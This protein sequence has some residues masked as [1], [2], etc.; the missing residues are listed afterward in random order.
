VI[1]RKNWWFLGQPQ[2]AESRL[3]L[4]S[5]V[6]SAN[7]HHLISDRYLKEVL[8][9]LASAR[10]QAPA[11]LELGS[12]RLLRCLPDGW[13][14]SHPDCVRQFRRD[15]RADRSERERYNKARR[16]IEQRQAEQPVPAQ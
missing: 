14:E 5:I 1:G 9:K 6:G 8:R 13:S 12:E 15:E 2:A 4:F 10:Q 7:R 3:R 16:R 11:E